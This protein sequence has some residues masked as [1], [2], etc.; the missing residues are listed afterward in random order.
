MTDWP[1]PVAIA[2]ACGDRS[3]AVQRANLF[4]MDIKCGDVE[5][6]QTVLEYLNSL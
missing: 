3:I 4:D 6:S 5:T 2:D 1:I